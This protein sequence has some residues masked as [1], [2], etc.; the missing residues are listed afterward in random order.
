MTQWKQPT[1]MKKL[2][3]IL[4]SLCL[5]I[6]SVAIAQQTPA[7]VQ[8][9]AYTILGATA[10]IGTGAVIDNSVIIFENG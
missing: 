4:A 6:T 8:T 9:G 10:H 3:H 1:K 5:L 2:T 7:P